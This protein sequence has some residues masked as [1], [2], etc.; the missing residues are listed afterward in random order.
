MN[1]RSPRFSGK[2]VIIERVTDRQR[3][4]LTE[5]ED[6]QVD[7]VGKIYRKRQLTYVK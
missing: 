2:R 1:I 6:L 7:S 3:R 5:T 4:R